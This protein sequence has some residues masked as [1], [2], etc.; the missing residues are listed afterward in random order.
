MVVP[1]R[2]VQAQR[3]VALAPAVAGALVLFNDDG[4]HAELP[5]PRA[6]RDAAL[7]AA[8][9]ERV[10]LAGKTELGRFLLALLLPCR[11]VLGRAMLAPNGRSKPA[12]SS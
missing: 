9:D 3:L 11:P 2:V 5:E 1:D 8:D 12:G 4:R 10:G 6:E 7:A